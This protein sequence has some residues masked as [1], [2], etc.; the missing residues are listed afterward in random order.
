MPFENELPTDLAERARMMEGILIACAT[1]GSQDGPVYE[2][3]R[4][5]FMH[6]SSLKELL[7][8]FVRTDVPPVF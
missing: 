8:G 1:G 2:Q 6:D 5:E 4:R 7:P 3:L